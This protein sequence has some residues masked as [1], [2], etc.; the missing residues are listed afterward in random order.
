MKKWL[1]VAL[2]LILMPVAVLFAGCSTKDKEVVIRVN[3]DYVQWAYVGEDEWTNVISIED[4]KNALGEGYQGEKGEQ[5]EAGVDGRQVEF[6]KNETHI[7]WRYVGED[8]WHNLVAL[9]EIK[10]KDGETTISGP[11]HTVTFD[12]NGGTEI[13]PITNVSHLSAISKPKTPTR[14][15]YAFDGWYSDGDLWNFNGCLVSKDITLT[16][17]WNPL[18]T[19]T[20][21]DG[22]ATITGLTSFGQNLESICFASSID[23]VEVKKVQ[24]SP[25]SN[26]LKSISFEE[27]IEDVD[28][29]VYG[30]QNL[31]FFVLPDSC[32]TLN[33]NVYYGLNPDVLT[34]FR[35]GLYLGTKSNP[36]FYLAQMIDPNIKEFE[37]HSDCKF[38]PSLYS[39]FRLEKIIFAGNMNSYKK[40]PHYISY[41]N[42]DAAGVVEIVC[43]DGMFLSNDTFLEITTSNGETTK[44]KPKYY[45]SIGGIGRVGGII[46]IKVSDGFTIIDNGMFQGC[47]D[48]QSIE[49]PNSINS[50]GSEAFDGCSGL[51]SIVIPKN[52]TFI[53]ERAFSSCSSLTEVHISDLA[54]WFN[55]TFDINNSAFI[56]QSANPLYYAHHLYLNGTELT[57]IEIPA[58]ITK[59]NSYAFC[60][61]NSI[62]S[63]TIPSSITSIGESAFSDCSGLTSITI[64][65]S[66][67]SIGAYA[68]SGCSGLTSITVPSSVTNIGSEAFYDCSNLETI[69][70]VGTVAEF[71]TKNFDFG[72]SQLIKVVCTDGECFDTDAYFECTYSNGDVKYFK[73]NDTIQN[74]D[75]VTSVRIGYGVTSI[76]NYA[77]YGCS[78][79][80]SVTIPDGVTAIGDNAFN[81]CSSLTA[82]HISDLKSW[83]NIKFSS[84]Y[85]NPLI[86][87]HHLYLNETELTEIEIP[88][89]ITKINNFALYGASTIT[90]ITIPNSVT[91]IGSRAFSG[92]KKVFCEQGAEPLDWNANWSSG[93][94][95]VYWYRETKPTEEGNF[96]HYVDGEPVIW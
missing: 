2:A 6:S 79:L 60:G 95:S 71:K 55:I 27:G 1:F 8:V 54:A 25:S 45:S 30:C 40:L 21:K 15:G 5:G 70:F 96:W 53:G 94:E 4:I 61:A 11:K 32:K 3:D 88:A 77:F 75:K 35:N 33:D 64:P 19:Y 7:I 83:F 93:V 22:N 49:L 80:T 59:I 13:A 48:L 85:A 12:S 41:C 74:K 67:T 14:P 20:L 84:V 52:V 9:S 37:I 89:G 63:I 42:S 31:E 50:I 86:Y 72:L 87:A 28:I 56:G 47:R 24:I 57:E 23:G 73:T 16:A 18:F 38:A 36:Y 34:E 78:G 90:S 81:G 62:T 66:V 65:D 39:A 76:G 43:S 91:S 92:C 68:F 46:S 10:G 29:N 58:V 26:Y 17:K 44:I 82:V 51:T 69:N